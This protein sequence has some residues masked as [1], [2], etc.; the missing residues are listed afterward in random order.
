MI[1]ALTIFNR[2]VWSIA[3][4]AFLVWTVTRAW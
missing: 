4:A 1:K 3:F 2:I